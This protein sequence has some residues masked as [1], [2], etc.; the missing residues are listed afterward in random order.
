MKISKN[1]GEKEKRP[2]PFARL[3]VRENE[4]EGEERGHKENIK[5]FLVKR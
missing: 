4:N 3:Q 5:E 2:R 1:N